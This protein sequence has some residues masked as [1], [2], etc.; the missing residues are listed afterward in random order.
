MPVKLGRLLASLLAPRCARLDVCWL[1][2]DV[3][4]V[5]AYVERIRSFGGCSACCFVLGL[6]YVERLQVCFAV[7]HGWRCARARA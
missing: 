5:R 6:R 3:A 1:C 2:G 7:L 4:Q